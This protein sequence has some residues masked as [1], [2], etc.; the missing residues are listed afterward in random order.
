MYPSCFLLLF[1]FLHWLS[2][3]C[4]CWKLLWLSFFASIIYFVI[5]HLRQVDMDLTQSQTEVPLKI[6]STKDNRNNIILLVR[7]PHVGFSWSNSQRDHTHDNALNLEKK[8]LPVFRHVL[9][10]TLT[11]VHLDHLLP[12]SSINIAITFKPACQKKTYLTFTL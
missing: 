6:E 10:F 8:I 9:C 3:S 4:S 7:E 12:Q 5:A 11:V 2:T 1:R